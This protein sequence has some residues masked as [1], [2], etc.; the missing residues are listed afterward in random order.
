MTTIRV[1]IHWPSG[2]RIPVRI[3]LSA[4]THDL[5]ELL[6]FAL[7][8]KKEMQF[9]SQ[10]QILNDK[11]M[12]TEQGITENSNIYVEFQEHEEIDRNAAIERGIEEL[13]RES[14]RLC[15]IRMNN[16]NFR[17]EYVLDNEPKYY[18]GYEE[19]VIPKEPPKA[20]STDPLPV[21]WEED[22]DSENEQEPSLLLRFTSVEEARHFFS[23][24]EWLGWT[25]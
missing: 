9:F 18:D 15:D 24:G 3:P 12:L 25:W 14:L 19:T 22:S 1:M 7:V 21:A 2:A 11:D 8:P 13:Y 10:T 23:K 17:T 4:K 6:K 16:I 5:N 20:V